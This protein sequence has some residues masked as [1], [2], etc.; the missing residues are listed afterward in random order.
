MVAL[1]HV[2]SVSHEDYASGPKI[3]GK[4]RNNNNNV[5]TMQSKV[6]TTGQLLCRLCLTLSNKVV[7]LFPIEET[8]TGQI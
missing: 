1:N 2:H 4:E 7:L 6:C 8:T 3:T 5:K